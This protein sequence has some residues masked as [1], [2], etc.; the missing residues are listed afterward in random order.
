MIQL[1]TLLTTLINQKNASFPENWLGMQM[2]KCKTIFQVL[3]TFEN[4]ILPGRVK[5]LTPSGRGPALASGPVT[6]PGQQS[7]QQ[8]RPLPSPMGLKSPL[9]GQAHS[10][11]QPRTLPQPAQQQGFIG[12]GSQ[13]PA[14][15][16]QTQEGLSVLMKRRMSTAVHSEAELYSEKAVFETFF[17]LIVSFLAAPPLTIEKFSVAKSTTIIDR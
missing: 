13:S 9:Q 4:E 1:F 3:T 16:R 11:T 10:P 2:F 14:E 7:P 8:G 15:M 17:T 6:R 5:M 12:D